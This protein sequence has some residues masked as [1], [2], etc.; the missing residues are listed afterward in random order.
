[1]LWC[2]V[3]WL[4]FCLF[5]FFNDPRIGFMDIKWLWKFSCY[6]NSQ[7]WNSWFLTTFFHFGKSALAVGFSGVFPTAQILFS[8]KS[9]KITL[10]QI[11][12][13]WCVFWSYLSSLPFVHRYMFR[14]KL[15]LSSQRTRP[16]P[17]PRSQ[18]FAAALR[19]DQTHVM[20][21]DSCLP[22]HVLIVA[23]P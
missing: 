2:S 5:F 10:S 14:N 3:G 13:I 16:V 23:F 7:V 8:L 6:V 12:L 21:S 1:M 19:A 18:L 4:L 15:H 17:Q 11:D 20:P 9:V 22:A